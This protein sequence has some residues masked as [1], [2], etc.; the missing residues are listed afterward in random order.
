MVVGG[1]V[2][3]V[4]EDP[5]LASLLIAILPVM[6]L[7]IGVVMVRAVPLFR[8]MQAKL[9]R[10]NQVH[11]RDARGHPRHPRLRTNAP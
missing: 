3:A 6:M 1:I 5:P 10:I 11:A 2:M 7:V 8:A 4:R 9:D